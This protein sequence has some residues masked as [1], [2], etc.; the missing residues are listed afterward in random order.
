MPLPS[1]IKTFVSELKHFKIKTLFFFFIQ[2]S[3]YQ[4]SHSCIENTFTKVIKKIIRNPTKKEGN[5]RIKYSQDSS[6]IEDGTETP[7]AQ[8]GY[9]SGV[10]S[11]PQMFKKNETGFFTFPA[12][13]LIS[14]LFFFPFSTHL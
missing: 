2:E 14:T 13:I 7:G 9:S 4:K 8:A 10:F 12:R 6:N 5:F 1:N 11:L 3:I